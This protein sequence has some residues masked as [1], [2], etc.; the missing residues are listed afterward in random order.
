MALWGLYWIG[1]A[2][3][4]MSVSPVEADS[5]ESA[6]TLIRRQCRK[7][8]QDP[9]GETQEVRIWVP[10]PRA[11]RAADRAAKDAQEA[12]ASALRNAEYLAECASAGLHPDGAP[13]WI[14][15]RAEY[16]PKKDRDE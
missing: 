6:M 9:P 14:R 8:R 5:S 16:E 12:A 7:D 1:S 2:D 15:R 4:D 3:R 10:D 13:S 11:G